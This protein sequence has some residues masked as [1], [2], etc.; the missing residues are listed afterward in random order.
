MKDFA[1][2]KMKVTHKL[3]FLFWAKAKTLSEKEKM[4]VPKCFPKASTL[5]PLKVGIVS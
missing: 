1:E 3:H 4:L 5:G 2:D